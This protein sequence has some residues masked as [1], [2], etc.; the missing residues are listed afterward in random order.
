MLKYVGGGFLRGVPARDLSDD[1]AV[2][3]GKVR[4]IKSGLYS[5]IQKAIKPPKK[6]A[7][8]ER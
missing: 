4:L 6:K 2:K 1:E 3:Y 7:V 5:E 8:K